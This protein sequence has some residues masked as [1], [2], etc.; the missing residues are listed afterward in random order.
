MGVYEWIK[1]IVLGLT[2]FPVRAI[3]IFFLMLIIAFFCW[4]AVVG[5]SRDA[6]NS[7][8][9]GCRR[10]FLVP[11][12]YL[13]RVVAFV[14]GFYWISTKGTRSSDAGVIVAAPHTNMLDPL[15]M[16]WLYWPSGVSA[17]ENARV[18]MVGSIIR[19]SQAILVDRNDPESRHAAVDAIGERA[20]TDAPWPPTLVFAE[21][22]CSNGRALIT[23]KSGAFRPGVPIQPVAIKYS[24]SHFDPSW[25]PTGPGKLTL[26]FRMLTQFVNFVSITYLPVVYPEEEEKTNPHLYANNVRAVIANELQVPVTAHTYDDCRLQHKAI[27][28]HFPPEQAVVEFGALQQLFG[29][30]IDDVKLIMDRFASA[31]V[32]GS[33]TVDLEEFAALLGLRVSEPV[34]QAFAMFDTDASGFIDFREW[35]IGLALANGLDDREEVFKY[36]FQLFDPSAK[37]KISK[38]RFVSF[39]AMV[40]PD[41]TP[42]DADVLFDQV[43]TKSRGYISYSAFKAYGE[44]HPEYLQVFLQWNQGRAIDMSE[45]RTRAAE[46][47]PS[48]PDLSTYSRFDDDDDDGSYEVYEDI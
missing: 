23:F 39:M 1:T 3:L 28:D 41:M 5:L 33:G 37:G 21:G 24:F 11:A 6:L 32:D 9:S 42:E 7:P 35:L 40:F 45:W 14:A 27:R 13:C 48:D 46:I 22:T 36:A 12:Q 4:L 8:L 10:V 47:A 43:D 18:C 29:Y 19:A 31:D 34:R 30:N 25:V 2:L 38:T 26:L 15:F 16:Y 17:A 44:A 20:L